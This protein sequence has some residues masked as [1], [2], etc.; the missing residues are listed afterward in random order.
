MAH[1]YMSL[2][3]ED[4][5]WRADIASLHGLT[6][7]KNAVDGDPCPEGCA[8]GQERGV[9]A[10]R[11]GMAM[12][13]LGYNI[14][15]TGPSVSGDGIGGTARINTLAIVKN[16][17]KESIEK[18]ENPSIPDDLACVHNFVKDDEPVLLRFKAGQAL[19]FKDDVQNFLDKLIPEIAMLFESPDYVAKKNHITVSHEQQNR[20]LFKKIE[21]HVRD[22]GFL[23]IN[24]QQGS[25]QRPDVAPVI[26]GEPTPILRLEELEAK[27]EFLQ[28][29]LEVLKD[30]YQ[31]LKEYID[32]VFL[33][34]RDVQRHMKR[35]L[36]ALDSKMF[37]DM[38][39]GL[40][41]DLLE[42]EDAKVQIFVEGM[43]C[44]LSGRLEQ[45]RQAASDTLFGDVGE[46]ADKVTQAAMRRKR[47]ACSAAKAG[48]SLAQDNCLL[49]LYEVNVLVDNSEL[50]GPPVIFESYPTYRNLF[51]SIEC[52]AVRPMEQDAGQKAKQS[53]CRKIHAGSFLKANGGYLVLNL[54]DTISEVG[55]WPTLK[56]ALKNQTMEIQAF[57]PYYFI[58]SPSVKPEPIDIHVKV[59][60]LATPQLYHVLRQL[61]DD[62]ERV[63]KIWADFD[64]AM[65]RDDAALHH[66]CQRMQGFVY[67]SGLL[68]F[69]PSAVARLLELGVRHAG[70]REKISIAFPQ[71]LDI[72]EEANY[73]ALAKKAAIGD[74]INVMAADVE[75]ALEARRYRAGQ[76]EEK[77]QEL[78][79][80]GT[81]MINTSG[82]A[83][84]QVNGLAVLSIGQNHFGKPTRITATTSMGKSGIVN[85]ERESNLSGALHTKGMLILAGYLNRIF[86]Q[87]W[88]LVLSASIA[89]EQSYGG[90]D[91]DS[92]SST[93]IYALLSSL[94]GVP[95]KQGIAVTGS[96]NQMGEVQAIGGVNEKIE[97][98]Y[99]CCVQSGLTGEQGV[100]IPHANVQDL[101]LDR[102]VAEAVDRG[103]FH[104]WAVKNISEGIEILTG[105]DSGFMPEDISGTASSFAEGSIFAKVD[106]RLKKMSLAF[107]DYAH[108]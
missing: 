12:H 82:L 11:F 40:A 105:L 100:M 22:S 95:I 80:R 2:K 41:H 98:F 75:A 107:R 65:N 103:D 37:Q 58:L 69:A 36:F 48:C 83:V 51:G 74:D 72:M 28:E 70:R 84:G 14:F 60:V 57:D 16:L 93:E 94:S 26:N 49:S 9:A 46:Q 102:R 81:I 45:L 3:G 66:I 34:V 89:F 85:I 44:H 43:L 96:V 106:K 23:I 4:L 17:L 29:E 52:S 21:S 79:D 10:F 31:K 38:A 62:V 59:I 5:R 7:K 87:K 71:L 19:K 91:G 68:P 24:M 77:M 6:N 30:T 61:D 101:M 27:G 39:R 67:E 35:E 92:A 76:I 73:M 64:A 78:I 55:V 15:V 104:I 20:A 53:G 56:R 33:E 108:S 13:G 90:V 42:Y 8:I 99:D 1:T 97:G 50:T 63:F 25:A 86:G 88:P 54:R 47:V 18:E 32:T